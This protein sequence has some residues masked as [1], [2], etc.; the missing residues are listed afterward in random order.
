AWTL[1]WQATVRRDAIETTVTLRRSP[2]RLTR[3]LTFASAT[4]LRLDYTLMNT[5]TVPSPCLWALH[6]LMNWQQGMRII[7]PSSVTQGEI[8]SVSGICPLEAYSPATWPI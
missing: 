4:A 7:L 8:G 3:L 1:P 5:S 2:F 6:P